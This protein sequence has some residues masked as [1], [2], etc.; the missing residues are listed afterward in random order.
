M[1]LAVLLY[2]GFLVIILAAVMV[3]MAY[4]VLDMVSMEN[5]LLTNQFEVSLPQQAVVIMESVV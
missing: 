4:L 3:F 2:R 5:L 1:E